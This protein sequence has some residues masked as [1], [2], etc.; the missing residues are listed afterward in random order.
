MVGGGRRRACAVAVVALG[1]GG[2]LPWLEVE[3]VE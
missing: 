3:G 2:R 1:E